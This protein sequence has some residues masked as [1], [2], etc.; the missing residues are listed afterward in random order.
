MSNP[1]HVCYKVPTFDCPACQADE[2]EAERTDPNV[3][4]EN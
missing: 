3:V 2:R 4:T 1:A